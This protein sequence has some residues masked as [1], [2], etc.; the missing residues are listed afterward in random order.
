MA[1]EY[2]EALEKARKILKVA[3]GNRYPSPLGTSDN[4]T[5]LRAAL[6]APATEFAA[7]H[8][9]LARMAASAAHC[10]ETEHLKSML[11]L[12]MS[13]RLVLHEIARLVGA[14]PDVD[15]KF[16]T[17]HGTGAIEEFLAEDGDRDCLFDDFEKD[18]GVVPS[19][20]E[21]TPEAFAEAE[22]KGKEAPNG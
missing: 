14:Q 17:F 9:V 22:K 20:D 7:L 1:K 15:S 8:K 21:F 4:A 2:D 5:M 11:R 10:H 13:V 18:E 16:W 19:I 12:M 6:V 3:D